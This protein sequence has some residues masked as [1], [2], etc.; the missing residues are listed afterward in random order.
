M[1]YPLE[2]IAAVAEAATGT[3]S[4]ADASGDDSTF[5]QWVKDEH[6]AVRYWAVIGLLRMAALQDLRPGEK[7]QMQTSMR[8]ALA[9]PK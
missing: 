8:R 6:A 5:L 3:L 7:R 4:P 1:V 2:R 9:D